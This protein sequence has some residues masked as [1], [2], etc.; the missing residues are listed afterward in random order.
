MLE[1]HGK[2]A[3]LIAALWTIGA[4]ED[5][6]LPNYRGVL[7]SAL[8]KIKDQ[9]PTDVTENLTFSVTGIGLRCLELPQIIND[10]Q[11]LLLADIRVTSSIRIKVEADQAFAML[12]EQNISRQDASQLA[13][14]FY[15]AVSAEC[16]S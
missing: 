8:N 10:M 11:Y 5:R 9:L 12:C 14:E 4:A 3:Q 1:N 7:D 13:Q 6:H 16:D 2:P 15:A